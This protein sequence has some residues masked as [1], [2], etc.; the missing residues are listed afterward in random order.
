M[1]Q[2][3]QDFLRIYQEDTN[4]TTT[5]SGA[6][7]RDLVKEYY[8]TKIDHNQKELSGLV[9]SKGSGKV[10]GTVKVIGS[11]AEISKMKHGDIL[12][13]GMT[14]PDYVV[15]MKKA[16]AI[17]TDEGGM[18]SHAAIVS[19]ELGVPCI[20]GTKIATKLLKDGDKI[21]VDTSKGVVRKL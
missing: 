8:T 21:E 4:T 7:A 5:H 6:E 2:R 18:T 13:A 11:A 12:V 17:V 19:R 14:A 1:K 10:I 15:G 16:A 3:L 20:V 9:V